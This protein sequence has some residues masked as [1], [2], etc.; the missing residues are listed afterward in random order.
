VATSTRYLP[1]RAHVWHARWQADGGE[2]LRSR[3][4][5]GPELKLSA[6]ELARVEQALLEHNRIVTGWSPPA[7]YAASGWPLARL[8]PALAGR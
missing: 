3:G 4:P 1:A 8:D 2:A 6:A 5:S 7:I